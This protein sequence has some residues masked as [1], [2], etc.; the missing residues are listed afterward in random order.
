LNRRAKA[1]IA[2]LSLLS[3]AFVGVAASVSQ[4]NQSS[5]EL[6]PVGER[7]FEDITTCLTSGK[8]K[9]LD[10]F[11]LIDN[12]GSLSYTDVSEVRTEVLANSLEG[13]AS[14]SEQ[15]V[16]VSYA[17]ALFNANVQPIQN[18]TELASSQQSNT[19]T[20]F[21]NN[22]N[23]GTW[24]DWEEGLEFAKNQLESRGDSC[25]MLIWFTD[26]GIN[27]DGNIDSVFSSLSKLCRSGITSNS[28][29]NSSSYGIFESMKKNQ[30]SLF[31][32]LYQNDKSTLEQYR[33]EY[34]SEAQ[35]RVDLEKFLM[36][37]MVPLIEG[38]G[39]VGPSTTF[40]QVPKP[41]PLQCGELDESGFAPAGYH[42]GAFLNAEDPISLAFQFLK[43][44]A[45]ITGGSGVPIV[46]GKFTIKP[47]TAA[48]KIITSD[49]NWNLTGPEG[50]SLAASASNP[51]QVR[52][53]ASADVQT[54]EFD[55]RR[56]EQYIGEWK[57]DFDGAERAE[58]YVY[59]GL[60]IELDRDK[61][62]QV[63]GDRENTLTGQVIPTANF[64]DLPVDLSVFESRNLTLEV[65][66]NGQRV[67]AVGVEF[68]I[69]NNGQFKITKFTPSQVTGEFE[70]W[71]TLDLGGDF[72]PVSSRFT[73]S[74]IEATALAIPVSDVVRLSTLEGPT[75]VASGVIAVNGP[76]AADSSEFCLAGNDL[77][78]DDAQT[79][80]EK[81]DRVSGFTWSFDGQTANGSEVCFTVAQGETKNIRVE[82]TNPTQ[83]NAEVVSMRNTLSRSGQAEYSALVRFEFETRTQGNTAVTIAVIAI[84]LLLGILLPLVLLYVFNKLT[85]RFLP[86]ENTY[87][88]E[89]P[90]ILSSG[91]APKIADARSG[92]SGRGIEVGPQDFVA[93]VDQPA[94][95]EINTGLGIAIARVPLFPLLATWYEIQAHEGQRVLTMKSY[96]EKGPKTFADGRSSEM[97]P[98]MS[99]NWAM[100][101]A[102]V[103]LLKPEEEQ[104][105]GRLVVYSPMSNL[106]VYQEKV[107]DVLQT[108]GISD[109]VAELRAA[110][111]RDFENPKKASH[112]KSDGA[113][114]LQEET[115]TLN[116]PT[117]QSFAPSS[118]K[119]APPSLPTTT[120]GSTPSQTSGNIAPPPPPT[121]GS[122]KLAPPPP[123]SF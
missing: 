109:R 31:G 8:D 45:Q 7:A 92:A 13:L 32:V 3:L 122:G 35:A 58:L 114:T 88:A 54:I 16:K 18:W 78:T 100:S 55:V 57:F 53:G 97:S 116:A 117:T 12:S 50:S 95:P 107:N 1:I 102:D 51:G 39:Q 47:G 87:R 74:A 120:G 89:Y 26:G 93:Q 91:V 70:L 72:Q 24:T 25:K 42:N 37:F 44:Q 36:S 64:A 48:F 11:Y 17:A 6:S 62:S 75:G 23:L 27:P 84:L 10:V 66:A 82:V 14:F 4:A 69:D 112:G 108:P 121:P 28:L 63:I 85:T 98:N 61:V 113:P 73:L 90:V 118:G 29:G 49:T 34:G 105:P 103:D 60:T 94:S 115:G 20:K 86:L 67:P 9:A 106:S 68:E 33:G 22:S 96:G 52:V 5:G 21:V 65:L 46:D 76:T 71:I 99:D 104:L 80:A 81:K 43:L 77:R 79:A 59:P 30:I 15:G 111:K 40:A 110:A 56:L 41:G 19:I 119:L 101:F 83:A 2:S 123:P 38:R